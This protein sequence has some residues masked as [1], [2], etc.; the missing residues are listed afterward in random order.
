MLSAITASSCVD[1]L[2]LQGQS[3]PDDPAQQAL[4]IAA[5]FIAEE[6]AGELRRMISS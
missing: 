4:A 2:H 1:A 5:M 6:H 3:D